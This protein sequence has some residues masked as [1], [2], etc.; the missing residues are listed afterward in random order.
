[1]RAT[2]GIFGGSP[3]TGAAAEHQ[4]I[5]T[6]HVHGEIHVCCVYQYKLLPEIAQLIEDDVLDP[7]NIMDFNEWFHRQHPP[8]ENLHKELL[9][10]IEAD[11]RGR[12]ADPKHDDMSQVPEYIAQDTSGNM[13]SD[14]QITRTDAYEEGVNFKTHLTHLNQTIT[15]SQKKR[16]NQNKIF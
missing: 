13:W 14:N 1:M 7:Q 5:G 16:K 9:P 11:W 4:G 3:A 2:G 12:Y 6:P 15:N 10:E 8:D